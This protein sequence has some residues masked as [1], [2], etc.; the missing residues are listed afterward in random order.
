MLKEYYN[1]LTSEII[2]KKDVSFL[3][4]LIS[5]FFLPM[6]VNLSTFTLI[7]SI[8]LKVIQVVVLKESFFKTRALKVSSAIGLLFFIYILIN[9][10]IQTDLSYTIKVFE[11]EFQ[12]WILLFLA[13][14]LLREKRVNK[15][16]FFSFSLGV[17]VTIFYVLGNS[18]FE[19]IPFTQEIFEKTVDIHHT[20][21][22]MY[23]LLIVNGLLVNL[24]WIDKLGLV[25]YKKAI[26]FL[27]I[28]FSFI[29]IYRLESK[30]SIVIFVV[31][32]SF[33]L[34]LKFSKKHILKYLVLGVVL[35]TSLILF[36]KK[37]NVNYLNALDYRVEIWEA[38]ID[39]IEENFFSGN[40][41]HPE[42]S[43]L[44]FQHYLAGEYYFLDRDL[45]CHNQYLSIMIKYGFFGVF[46]FS[47]LL[48][49]M[50]RK[51]N[52]NTQS[53]TIKEV[54]GFLTIL[55]L[56][57]YIESIFDR[58]HGIVFFTVFYNYYLVSIE[59]VKS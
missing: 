47:L 16:L 33:H 1:T 50:V 46:I 56:V 24:L 48:V 32:I 10:L 44:N 55:A 6:S 17:L 49:N 18:L 38:S 20:Y 11:K 43:L 19:G 57:F 58:H 28:T 29:L 39:V 23:L 27:I 15:M 52:I 7:V 14:I 31:L 42:K 59:N 5:M 36:N 3:V 2:A 37:A 12:H 4:F 25:N 8:C 26:Y 51:T 53:K 9:S 13:P 22:T 34:L 30:V 54:V 45:N 40:L 21:L 35:I 41:K